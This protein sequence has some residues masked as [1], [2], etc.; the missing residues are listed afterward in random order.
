M[1]EARQHHYTAKITWTGAADGPTRD[2][3]SYSRAHRIEMTGKPAIEASSDPSFRG[4]PSRHNPEEMLVA[5][6][7]ACH[8]LWYLHLC[9][10]K[11]VVVLDYVDAAEGTMLEESRNGRMTEVVLHPRVTISP[12]SD[13]AKAKALHERAHSECF[14]A[15][16]MNFPVRCQPVIMVAKASA[17]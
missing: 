3:E 5:S 15:N 4:D 8:M 12:D 1:S 2:Y 13:A 14:I 9:A 6:L 7:S 11:G 10:V 17:A 16:S